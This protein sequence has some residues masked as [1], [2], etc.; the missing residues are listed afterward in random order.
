MMD[1]NT[2]IST[3]RS[4]MFILGS[5]KSE[6]KLLTAYHHQRVTKLF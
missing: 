4:I 2:L 6:A 5:V 1:Q 3:S